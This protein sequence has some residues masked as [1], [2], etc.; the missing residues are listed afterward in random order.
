MFTTDIVQ[1]DF[2]ALSTLFA[3][4]FCPT[5]VEAALLRP[6]AGNNEKITILMATVYPAT[7][8]SPN[9]VI[10]RYNP[11]QLV[12]EIKFWLIP[13]K[14]NFRSLLIIFKSISMVCLLMPIFLFFLKNT[15]V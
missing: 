9:S 1:T 4:R 8:L 11:T 6:H 5:N 12:V 15:L 3:P 10:I 7:T 2:S 13:P 14:D